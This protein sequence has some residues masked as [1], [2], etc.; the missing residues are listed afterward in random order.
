MSQA[1]PGFPTSHV[2]FS[3]FCVHSELRR[4]VIVLF[5]DIGDVFDHRCLSFLFISICILDY[6]EITSPPIILWSIFVAFLH[7]SLEVEI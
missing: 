5:V 2:V 1:G 6:K 3:P 4:E 7:V